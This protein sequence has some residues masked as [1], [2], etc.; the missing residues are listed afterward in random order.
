MESL[1]KVPERLRKSREDLRLGLFVELIVFGMVAVVHFVGWNITFIYGILGYLSAMHTFTWA[2]IYAVHCGI[3]SKEYLSTTFVFIIMAAV[4]DFGALAWRVVII[5]GCDNTDCA[6]TLVYYFSW[7]TCAL[8]FVLGLVDI[9]YAIIVGVIKE[10]TARHVENS[11]AIIKRF[12][13]LDAEFNT[14]RNTTQPSVTYKSVVTP[15]PDNKKFS[16]SRSIRK[17]L[18]AIRT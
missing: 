2:M 11:E 16:E 7:V 17:R 15:I 6:N 10:Q 9:A 12:Q 14:A 13:Q 18:P 3:T 1:I 4:L 5:S 8:T